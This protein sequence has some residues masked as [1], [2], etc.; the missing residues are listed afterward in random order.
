MKK[1]IIA[2]LLGL[3]LVISGCAS[4][5]KNVGKGLFEVTKGA[6]YCKYSAYKMNQFYW[7]NKAIRMDYV[8]KVTAETSGLTAVHVLLDID[9]KALQDFVQDG[10]DKRIIDIYGWVTFYFMDE[11]C[12]IQHSYKCYAKKDITFE[13][14]ANE[15]DYVAVTTQ[16]RYKWY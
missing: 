10:F 14:P 16:F 2:I 9:K 5:S 15:Y 7:F 11:N 8:P 4:T 6:M 12:T 1:L 13:I 3:S